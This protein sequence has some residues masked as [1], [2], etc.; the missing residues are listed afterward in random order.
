MYSWQRLVDV[1]YTP[2]MLFVL[3]R[4]VHHGWSLSVSLLSLSL[5]LTLVTNATATT[6]PTW[7]RRRTSGGEISSAVDNK[8][9]AKVSLS[10]YSETLQRAPLCAPSEI[11]LLRGR[12][13]TLPRD[14]LS[15][16]VLATLMC[17]LLFPSV[18]P[19]GAGACTVVEPRSTTTMPILLRAAA[20]QVQHPSVYVPYAT[21][22][23][24]F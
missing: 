18:S 13:L 4:G 11:D 15:S 19:L 1:T 23:R 7:K 21:Y 16:T 5:S 24:R 12:G 2:L 22:M 10:Q 17:A 8:R 9:V 20:A 3:S 6:P 14:A